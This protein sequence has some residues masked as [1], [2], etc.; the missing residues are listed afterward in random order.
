MEN[1]IED[2]KQLKIEMPSD[3]KEWLEKQARAKGM[4]EIIK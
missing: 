3:M 2:I 1:K 4:L